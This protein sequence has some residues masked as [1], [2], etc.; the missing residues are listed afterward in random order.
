MVADWRVLLSQKINNY[1][2]WAADGIVI[3]ILL[4]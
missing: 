3:R 2:V 1:R 4:R